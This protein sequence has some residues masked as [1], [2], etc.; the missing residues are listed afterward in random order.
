MA[1]TVY[2]IHGMC[3]GAW[4]WD[5]YRSFFET[6][7]YRCL[8]PTLRY[9]DVDPGRAPPAQLGTTGLLDYAGDLAAEIEQLGTAPI[10]VGHSLG[11]LLAQILSSRVRCKALILLGS[12]PPAGILAFRPSQITAFGSVL[13][14]WGW[15][16]QPIRPTFREAAR[17]MLGGLSS[18]DQR[19][20]YARFVYESGRAAFEAGLWF[21]DRRQAARVDATRVR[22]PVLVL[23]GAR[24]RVAPPPV[25]R[26]IARKYAPRSTY[27]PL[28]G[29][30]HWLV[31]EPG[32]LEVAETIDGWLVQTLG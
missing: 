24:D 23:S 32:W 25:S 4:V 6:R 31:A 14:R 27:C 18:T 28:E 10:L 2:L 29:H 17:G 7:G 11:G 3:G 12:A 1:E 20:T 26:Q 5:G 9:H 30:G 13:A 8:A 16:R 19:R 15:W 21:L 22:C